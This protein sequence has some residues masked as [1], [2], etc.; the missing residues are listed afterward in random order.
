M[1]KDN[2]YRNG[3]KEDFLRYSGDGLSDEDRHA[4]EREMQKDPF[5]EEAVEGLSAISP[6]EAMADISELRDR[7]NKRTGSQ[8]S[9]PWFRIAASVALLLAVGVLYF[10]VIQDK[11]IGTDRVAVEAESRDLSGEESAGDM[12]PMD[13]SEKKAGH[14]PERPEQ[15]QMP[16]TAGESKT[17]E[18]VVPVEIQANGRAETGE[19]TKEERGTGTVQ[20]SG[21][22][23]AADAGIAR[24]PEAQNELSVEMA[25]DDD[26]GA[27]QGTMDTMIMAY[28]EELADIDVTGDDYASRAR[29]ASIA[30]PTALNRETEGDKEYDEISGKAV[31]PDVVIP[32]SIP[33][34][35][36]GGMESFEEYISLNLRFPEGDSLSA[37]GVVRM[38]FSIGQDGRPRNIE[39]TETPGYAFSMEAVRLLQDGPE[40]TPVFRNGVPV[41][42]K[43]RLNIE[44]SR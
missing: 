10:T 17:V 16:A 26:L 37:G 6:E 24:E 43:V 1:S 5:A 4:L 39:I 23:E 42:E 33:A 30:T 32:D 40:W 35:P 44:F 22:E 25:L 18:S 3:D 31:S 7:L 19:D 28:E 8:N 12:E 15:Q 14:S 21:P 9:V 41:N 36:A 2:K 34:M 29:Q 38:R 13:E 20:Q 27:G 11:L